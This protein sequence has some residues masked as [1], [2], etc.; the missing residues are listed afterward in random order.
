MTDR[1]A[2]YALAKKVESDVGTHV[3]ILINNA[4]IVTGK[5]FL[6]CPD[7]MIQKTFEV[8][9]ISH[10]WTC[11]AFLPKI[12]ENDHGHLVTIASTAG[13][14]G[15]SGLSDYCASKFG[16]LG[17]AESMR[18]E[19]KKLGLKNVY[20]TTVCP[21]YINTGMFDGVRSRF[22]FLLPIL[23]PDFVADKIVDAIRT[24]QEILITPKFCWTGYLMRAFLPVTVFDHL[25]QA[26]GISESMDDFKGR[27]STVGNLSGNSAAGSK[28]GKKKN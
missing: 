26:L 18:F 16:A 17:F 5:K 21:F 25:A 20:S 10:F 9:T 22:P 15:V 8:N 27:G 19:F 3:T 12:I 4:G 1:E 24:N 6:D 23:E 11:K 7:G 13:T 14:M 2:V 28:D